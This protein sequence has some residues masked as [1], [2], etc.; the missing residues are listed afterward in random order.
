[1]QGRVFQAGSLIRACTI[2]KQ[3]L[4]NF[5]SGVFTYFRVYLVLASGCFEQCH[6]PNLFYVPFSRRMRSSSACPLLAATIKAPLT[7]S[8]STRLF[9][10][11]R[12]MLG[13]PDTAPKLTAVLPRESLLLTSA[14]ALSRASTISADPL[15][16]AHISAVIPVLSA[17]LGF[18]PA[19]RKSLMAY[20]S[21]FA[22]LSRKASSVNGKDNC[23][24]FMRAASR[25]IG[26][27]LSVFL[28]CGFSGGPRSVFLTSRLYVRICF[29]FSDSDRVLSSRKAEQ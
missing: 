20:T 3:E 19:A 17:T 26:S 22:A 6:A 5:H 8:G 12:K 7:I 4:N 2:G 24:N 28:P 23:P 29:A 11:A 10:S 13:L 15:P 9:S 18:I 16:A 14:F 25:P 1:M 27:C 21:P